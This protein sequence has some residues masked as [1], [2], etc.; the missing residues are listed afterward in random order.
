[1]KKR[2]VFFVAM[3]M[4]VV[5]CGSD[6]STG[7]T[8]A[9]AGTY[10]L[11][12]GDLTLEEFTVSFEPPTLTGVLTLTDNGQYSL[13]ALAPDEGISVLGSGMFSISGS[14]ITFDNDPGITATVSGNE[15]SVRLVGGVGALVL[16][17]VK[18]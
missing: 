18:P 1:M 5:A 11:Q 16:F 7:S 10:N 12:R 6:S 14:S 4:L 13:S 3:L 8:S 9:V 2:D 15:I 17:Y